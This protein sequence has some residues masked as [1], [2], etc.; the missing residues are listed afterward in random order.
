MVSVSVDC[1]WVVTGRSTILYGAVRGRMLAFWRVTWPSEFSL[2]PSVAP[3]LS[4]HYLT[5]PTRC[6]PPELATLAQEG[7]PTT[8]P[9]LQSASYSADI[10]LHT[11]NVYS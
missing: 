8:F 6:V 1:A 4:T 3:Y 2:D 10:Y 7:C 5:N 9:S 11:C